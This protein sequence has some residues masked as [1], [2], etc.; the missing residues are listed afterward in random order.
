MGHL[1]IERSRRILGYLINPYDFYEASLLSFALVYELDGGGWF[2]WWHVAWGTNRLTS[3]WGIRSV[4]W[5]P[6]DAYWQLVKGGRQE[7]PVK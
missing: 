1:V 2:H 6:P 7:C 4:W 3:R 5:C